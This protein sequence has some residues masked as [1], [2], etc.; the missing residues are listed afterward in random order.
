MART[1]EM[2][3]NEQSSSLLQL[4]DCYLSQHENISPGIFTLRTIEVR[5]F[6]VAR[7]ILTQVTLQPEQ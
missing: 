4:F 1:I 5:F 3:D 6:K 7:K 2:Q